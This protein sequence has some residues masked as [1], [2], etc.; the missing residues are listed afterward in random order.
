MD[1]ANNTI[2]SVNAN[3][4]SSPIEKTNGHRSILFGIVI[5]I[6]VGIMVGGLFPKLAIKFTI[7]GEV[8]LNSLMMIVVP[9]VIFSMIV[10][11]RR[12]L[13]RPSSLQSE[14]EEVPCVVVDFL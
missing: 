7:F 10:G 13:W 2:S 9:L 6:I 4:S 12:G 8:F 1:K 11:M 14:E 5:A 3:K